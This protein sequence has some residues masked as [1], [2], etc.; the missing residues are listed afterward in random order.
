[1]GGSSFDDCLNRPKANLHPS[2]LLG[3]IQ[4]NGQKKAERWKGTSHWPMPLKVK[5]KCKD[6][7]SAMAVSGCRRSL[8]FRNTR[9][10]DAPEA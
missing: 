3:Q 2:R 8:I 10:D 7:T 1:M 9:E 4:T 5:T 6:L